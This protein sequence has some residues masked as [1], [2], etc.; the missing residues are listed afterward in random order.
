MQQ[1]DVKRLFI[2]LGMHRSGTS[3]LTRALKVFDIELGNNHIP[4]EPGVNAKGFWED[5]DVYSLNVDMLRALAIRWDH[6][7]PIRASDIQYL[8]L[9]SFFPRAQALLAARMDRHDRFGIKD[10]RL[11]R[12]LPFWQQ[13]FASLDIQPH[14]LIALRHPASVAQSLAV[15]NRFSKEKSLALWL[16]YTI[17][18]LRHTRDSSRLIV[19]YDRVLHSPTSELRRIGQ[20]WNLCLNDSELRHYSK[21][22]LDHSLRHHLGSDQLR[23][24]MEIGPLYKIFSVLQ[25]AAADQV[26]IDRTDCCSQIDEWYGQ[27]KPSH[28]SRTRHTL[29]R[30]I[31]AFAI[32]HSV[33]S[34]QA[35]AQH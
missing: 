31:R 15:R 24:F 16:E 22:F 19:D 11:S 9:K 27:I 8:C 30:W 2:V 34:T 32:N 20:H 23:T 17:A 26:D 29:K 5:R 33:A 14:Y 13:V 12:L 4:A 21:D 6:T 7:T 25:K 18:A 3:A 10:P 35:A 28:T 1:T